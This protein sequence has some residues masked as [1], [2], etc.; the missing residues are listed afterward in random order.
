MIKWWI[1]ASFPSF[2]LCF[3]ILS[4]IHTSPDFDVGFIQLLCFLSIGAN[5]FK[6]PYSQKMPWNQKHTPQ[7]R[8]KYGQIR[9]KIPIW[10]KSAY[11]WVF[12]GYPYFHRKKGHCR[13][14]LGGYFLKSPY[15][16]GPPYYTVSGALWKDIT[17]FDFEFWKCSG[18]HPDGFIWLFETVPIWLPGVDSN[19]EPY[20]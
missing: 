3:T 13:S 16:Y 1:Y 15:F 9:W 8:K 19:H 12:W 14:N 20:S 17:V 10:V 4:H 11:V 6:V 18:T 7:T 5:W 2:W